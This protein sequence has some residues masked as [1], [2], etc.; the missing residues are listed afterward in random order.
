MFNLSYK[1]FITLVL[2]C[3]VILY[4]IELNQT[5]RID[6]SYYAFVYFYPKQ[7]N[8]FVQIRFGVPYKN[9]IYIKYYDYQY[10]DEILEN[11][12]LYSNNNNDDLKFYY[13][14]ENKN[15]VFINF[16][17]KEN[18]KAIGFSFNQYPFDSYIEFKRGQLINIEESHELQLDKVF[19]NV[20]LINK[21]YLKR[22][23][24]TLGFYSSNKTFSI[25]VGTYSNYLTKYK[26]NTTVNYDENIFFS[27]PD[28]DDKSVY[29]I[30]LENINT[31]THLSIKLFEKEK[32]KLFY[33][34]NGAIYFQLSKEDCQ[35]TLLGYESFSSNYF[36]T[37]YDFLKGY[38]DIDIYLSKSLGKALNFDELIQS[39]NKSIFDYIN[40]N[41]VNFF[42]IK[43][44]E[45]SFLAI[46]H[47]QAKSG[48]YNKNYIYSQIPFVTYILKNSALNNTFET[49]IEED[50]NFTLTILNN[51]NINL[52]EGD[53]YLQTNTQ[54]ISITNNYIS[55]HHYPGENYLLFDNRKNDL[56]IKINFDFDVTTSFDYYYNDTF[57][58]KI[59][60]KDYPFQVL[61]KP[62]EYISIPGFINY[63]HHISSYSSSYEKTITGLALRKE[64]LR[65]N[66]ISEQSTSFE[67]DID[68]DIIERYNRKNPDN[69]LY[70]YFYFSKVFSK[71]KE[72]I[73]YYLD[74]TLDLKKDKI[75]HYY[76]EDIKENFFEIDAKEKDTDMLAFQIFSCN[77]SQYPYL[78]VKY[79]SSY[80]IIQDYSSKNPN[81]YNK[82]YKLEDIKAKGSFTGDFLIYYHL[83]KS[84][85]N[86]KDISSINFEI[87]SYSFD[88]NRK[89]I[90][91]SIT[92][93]LYN[94]AVSYEIFYAKNETMPK[95]NKCQ[96][97]EWIEKNITNNNIHFISYEYDGKSSSSYFNIYLDFSMDIS[98]GIMAQYDLLIYSKQ[99]NNQQF[100]NI[101]DESIKQLFKYNITNNFEKII[102]PYEEIVFLYD[103]YDS[104][105]Y[106]Y[107][108]FIDEQKNLSDLFDIICTL[109]SSEIKDYTPNLNKNYC[110]V[111]KESNS[112]S[113]ILKPV[114]NNL[115]EKHLTISIIKRISIEKAI[116]FKIIKKGIIENIDKSYTIIKTKE[117]N[118]SLLF[119][120]YFYNHIIR[121][122]TKN[123]D[124]FYVEDK[125]DNIKSE[126]KINKESSILYKEGDNSYITIIIPFK[127]I[128]LGENITFEYIRLD[129]I[130]ISN[131]DIRYVNKDLS[132]FLDHKY[133]LNIYKDYQYRNRVI[134][135]YNIYYETN[136]LNYYIINE[137]NIPNNE[138]ILTQCSSS[139]NIYLFADRYMKTNSN[140][141]LIYTLNNYESIDFIE[142]FNEPNKNNNIIDYNEEYRYFITK[143][144]TFQFKFK[145]PMDNFF[146][147]I[148]KFTKSDLLISI[149]DINYS[150]TVDKNKI[151]IEHKMGDSMKIK[152]IKTEEDSYIIIVIYNNKK[153]N[154][155]IKRFDYNT[156]KFFNTNEYGL[157]KLDNKNKILSIFPKI[158]SNYYSYDSSQINFNFIISESEPNF[159][160]SKNFLSKSSTINI[161]LNKVNFNNL[162]KD[163]NYYIIFNITKT[164]KFI[165]I[166]LVDDFN[167]LFLDNNTKVDTENNKINL[168]EFNNLN[169][170]YNSYTI[171]YQIIPC[172]KSEINLLE[173]NDLGISVNKINKNYISNTTI[174]MMHHF[175]ITGK[176]YFIPFYKP[177]NFHQEFYSSL[178]IFNNNKGIIEIHF[179]P[180]LKSSTIIYSLIQFNSDSALLKEECQA[181]DIVNKFNINKSNEY[182][183]I[184]IIS[185]ES[186]FDE[187]VLVI[188]SKISINDLGEYLN[189]IAKL[190]DSFFVFY[191]PIKIDNNDN[192]TQILLGVFIP[193][194]IIL[195]VILGFFGY[196][197]YKK[198]NTGQKNI[199]S[200]GEN[201]ELISK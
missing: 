196:R 149:N 108:I 177:Y 89:I 13:K 134:H 119:E 26:G 81:F 64:Y 20:Y 40:I 126:T 168:I 159:V 199:L 56:I 63:H 144:D 24:N 43:C 50:F 31:P 15:I 80:I 93:N 10:E 163:E 200:D 160:P 5:L 82:E 38:G 34:S 129:E 92:N 189:I 172:D 183:V 8:E 70:V 6:V 25:N 132:G 145:S 36:Y 191:K 195:L 146:I 30:I 84:Y 23:G 88:F 44:S 153:I 51:S 184:D 98:Y 22:S 27:K 14:H 85:D 142:Y 110:S 49:R 178:K 167:R 96:A 90:T 68:N 21:D 55:L 60:Q 53:L 48:L 103:Y 91:L 188:K 154:N 19:L 79:G 17:V 75:C 102:E 72:Y 118:A 121:K 99:I 86:N 39:S 115:Y 117:E 57:D 107:Y 35:K 133:Q 128:K 69:P 112:I 139:K 187:C 4:R 45:D 161:H 157:I 162:M 28:K 106:Y 52:N 47:I 111:I 32:Y 138:S 11:E 176:S 182:N 94:E 95:M 87:K 150:L 46:Q 66:I 78:K 54:N 170:Y 180:V 61:I 164:V 201:V 2:F 143:N 131:L 71:D 174:E 125:M 104:K 158:I 171:L 77:T 137:D 114:Q 197:Y 147:K 127:N 33:M 192:K 65:K 97:L 62:K 105:E 59:Y 135:I 120:L 165:Y 74:G 76:N 152:N 7:D 73:S 169:Y 12:P 130:C 194:S 198:K 58:E 179:I 156:Y 109:S 136:K 37:A 83:Y 101:K 123:Y 193:F 67:F 185:S 166:Y 113:Y 151:E 148:K 1:I 41:K 173:F 181:Y 155:N 9:D 124:M 100:I 29:F 175:M 3:K 16:K 141:D 186:C 122:V 190:S 116:K 42:T 18:V 140:Y